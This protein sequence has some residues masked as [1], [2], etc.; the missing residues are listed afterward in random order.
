MSLRNKGKRLWLWG[1]VAVLLVLG[2]AACGGRSI[3]ATGGGTGTPSDQNGTPALLAKMRSQGYATVGFANENPYAYQEAD[4]T[5]TGEAV[6]VARAIL[7]ELGINDLKG[8]LAE[9]SALI[10][11]LKAKHFDIITAGMF[12]TPQ[13]AQ[14]VLFADP[15]YRIGAALAVKSGNPKNLH[16]YQDIAAQ[17]DVKVAVMQGAAE[18]DYL[19]KSGVKENQIV[20]V[21]D[22]PQA[23]QALKTGRVDA[24]TMTG[25]ALEALL[26]SANAADVER[27][28]D[29]QQ[30][31]IDGKEVWGYGAAAFR[32]EDKDLRDLYNQKLH[33][34]EKSG[35]LLEIM[36]PFGFTENEMPNGITADEV[37]K[38]ESQ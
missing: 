13:R 28:E 38:Q 5:L 7:G 4:G 1:A 6:E 15:E 35:Q 3:P 20:S 12:I 27:V 36:K 9:F 31:V 33:E 11:G 34:L 32:K 2:L 22:Q 18:E 24:I 25:P 16:S 14:E 19:L 10:P 29:F 17:P 23:L 26:K 21:Q 37:L 8:V 30:P